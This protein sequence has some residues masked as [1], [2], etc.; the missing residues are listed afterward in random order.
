[1][2]GYTRSVLVTTTSGVNH[3]PFGDKT[4]TSPTLERMT[5]ATSATS[6]T[7]LLDAGNAA[8]SATGSASLGAVALGGGAIA[9]IAVGGASVVILIVAIWAIVRKQRAE[10][11]QRRSTSSYLSAG[12]T[13]IG[14]EQMT[15]YPKPDQGHYSPPVSPPL[16]HMLR[17]NRLL[18][19]AIFRTQHRNRDI[20][21]P[22]KAFV[23]QQSQQQT[24]VLQDS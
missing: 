5:S 1:M 7:S 3:N 24:L 20:I 2:T 22:Q 13:Y 4:S 10:K 6:A 9:G 17:Q 19:M 14:Q 18:N 8:T 11:M 12:S 21:S 23:R 16:F 15:D